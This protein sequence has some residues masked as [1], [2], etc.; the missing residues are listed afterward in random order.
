[1]ATDRV[2][3]TLPT[4][5]VAELDG[6]VDEWGYSSRS[7]ASREALRGFLADHH[8]DTS[9][10]RPQRGSITI[11]YD[12]HVR[13][14]SDDL[15]DVQHA[16]EEVIV[17]TQHVHFDP[18]LCLETLVVNGAAGVIRELLEGINGIDGVEQ[19]RFT[20]V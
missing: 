20:A 18:D 14:L 8:W 3:L 9:P 17:A 4:E 19:V 12:H 13:G 7:S 5:L 11:V 15:L 2:S 1:M 6:V 10:D 16:H